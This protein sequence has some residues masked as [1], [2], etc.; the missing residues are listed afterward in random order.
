[1]RHR[2]NFPTILLGSAGVA[3]IL[4]VLFGMACATPAPTRRVVDCLT[5]PGN[6]ALHCDGTSY[7]WGDH[8]RGYVCRTLDDDEY[9]KGRRP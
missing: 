5:D 1:M 4:F 9:L 2:L 6:N 8:F 7:Q 3:L